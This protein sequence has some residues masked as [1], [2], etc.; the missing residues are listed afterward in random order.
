MEKRH[1]AIFM[2]FV[3][4]AALTVP[5]APAHAANALTKLSRGVVNTATGILEVPLQVMDNDIQGNA[6]VGAAGGFASGVAGAVTRTLSGLWD[7]VTFAL[8]PYDKAIVQPETLFQ[9]R[10]RSLIN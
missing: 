5:V 3:M 9:R 10:Y 2:L 4:G 7:V 1:L 6:L 8:P